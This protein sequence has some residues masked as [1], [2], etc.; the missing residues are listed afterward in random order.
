MK[1]IVIVGGGITGLSAALEFV[2][3]KFDAQIQILESANRLGGVLETI[4]PDGYLI[5]RSADNFATMIPNAKDLS[6]RLGLLPELIQPN[7]S[8]RQA[9]VYTNGKAHPIPAGFSL[10]Q[11]T[12]IMSILS[13][14]VLSL[15]GKLR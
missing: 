2:A 3:A 1:N 15:S 9:F 6:Q 12:R 14:Q 4:H 10:M 11:P 8:G 7:Q 5:E 13:T